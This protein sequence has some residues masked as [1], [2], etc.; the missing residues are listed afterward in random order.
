MVYYLQIYRAGIKSKYT[1]ESKEKRSLLGRI[2]VTRHKTKIK[3]I[4][5]ET[6]CKERKD[7]F[8]K[9]IKQ[10]NSEKK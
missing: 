1:H 3:E 4:L 8:T 10:Y 2:S 9:I 5:P 7:L 6:L